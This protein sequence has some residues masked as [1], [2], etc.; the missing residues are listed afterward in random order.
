M[1]GQA[2]VIDREHQ[3]IPQMPGKCQ[4]LHS[5]VQAIALHTIADVEITCHLK[6]VNVHSLAVSFDHDVKFAVPR[7]AAQALGDITARKNMV[8]IDF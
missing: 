7:A 8:A 1:P 3:R 5:K 4:V 6:P 2:R